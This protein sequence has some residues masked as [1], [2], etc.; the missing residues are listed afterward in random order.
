MPPSPD[1]PGSRRTEA[2]CELGGVRCAELL[3]RRTGLPVHLADVEELARRGM[4][5]ITQLYKQRPLYR[6]TEVEA[7]AADPVSC[8][9]LAD[10]VAAR[11]QAPWLPG[12]AR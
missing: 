8:A 5:Q 12:Q 10:I 9:E 3:A 2:A 7:L 1:Q 4:L 6:V 11:T